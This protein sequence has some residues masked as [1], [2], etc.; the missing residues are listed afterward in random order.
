MR[1]ILPATRVKIEPVIGHYESYARDCLRL[2]SNI[3]GFFCLNIDHIKDYVC[4]ICAGGRLLTTE[5]GPVKIR[6]PKKMK[7]DL[8]RWKGSA[9]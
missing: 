5:A 6:V 4:Q 2:E 8:S 1:Q 7:G 9:E 3:L